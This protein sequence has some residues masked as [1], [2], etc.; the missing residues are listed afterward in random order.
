[1]LEIIR[2]LMGISVDLNGMVVNA[3][4]MILWPIIGFNLWVYYRF[5]GTFG[6]L[7]MFKKK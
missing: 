3:K 1:M 5:L 7:S 4:W 2:N 6:L